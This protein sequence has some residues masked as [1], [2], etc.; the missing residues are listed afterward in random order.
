M[1][2]ILVRVFLSM[3]ESSRLGPPR[4]R[5]LGLASPSRCR[6]GSSS[7]LH[8][9]RFLRGIFS[10]SRLSG[11]GGLVHRAWGGWLHRFRPAAHGSRAPRSRRRCPPLFCFRR[12]PGWSGKGPDST[13]YS[14]MEQGKAVL[15]KGMERWIKVMDQVEFSGDHHRAISTHRSDVSLEEIVDPDQVRRSYKK[16]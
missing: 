16:G 9:S 3:V 5:R 10:V 6:C 2:L 8:S 1:T 15:K 11:S 13:Y 7:Y 4:G 12:S 14:I